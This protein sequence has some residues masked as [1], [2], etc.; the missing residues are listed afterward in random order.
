VSGSAEDASAG[1]PEGTMAGD[2]GDVA[3]AV[4]DEASR[5]V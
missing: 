5:E 3:G 4:A 2:A 1:V